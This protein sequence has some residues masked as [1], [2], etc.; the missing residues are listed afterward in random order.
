[1]TLS[2]FRSWWRRSGIKPCH[3]RARR[4][5]M[6]R[7]ASNT[8]WIPACAGTTRCWRNERI[9]ARV[10]HKLDSRCAGTTRCWRNERIAYRVQHKLDSRLRGNDEMLA[11]RANSGSR[12]P[13]R[14]A[15]TPPARAYP[16]GS[17]IPRRL[18]HTPP[19]RA[20][21]VAPAKAGAHGTHRAATEAAN[22]R[23][24]AR[25]SPPAARPPGTVCRSKHSLPGRAHSCGACRRCAR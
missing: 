3:P 14:L 6:E 23:R 25:R 16:A 2:K 20:Y 24:A 12:I 4:R 15:H 1:M 22:P 8:N 18:A 19:A 11:E 10:Q 5:P 21:P 17:R 7:I 9:A 13:R